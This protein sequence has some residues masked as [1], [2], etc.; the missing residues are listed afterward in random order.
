MI[1]ADKSHVNVP[2]IAQQTHWK[3]GLFDFGKAAVA[4]RYFNP[5]IIN[6][7]GADWLVVRKAA[8]EAGNPFGKNTIWSFKLNDAHKPQYGIKIDFKGYKDQ[9]WEDPRIIRRSDGQ[10]VI[11][12]VTFF[13]ETIDGDRQRWFGAHQQIA[14]LDKDFQPTLVIDPI[15]GNNGGSVM[16]NMVNPDGSPKNEKNWLWFEHGGRLHTVY[17]TDPHRVLTWKKHYNGVEDTYETPA[18]S[19]SWWRFGHARGGTPPVLVGDKYWSFFHSSTPWTEWTSAD[20]RRY[21]MGAYAFEAKPPF[22][23]TRFSKFPLL[24]GSPYD[25]W[26]P[27][28]P[29]VVFPCGALLRNGTWLVTLG[30]NDMASAWIEIPHEELVERT[31]IYGQTQEEEAAAEPTQVPCLAVPESADACGVEAEQGPSDVGVTD[32]RGPELPA[33]AP[34][35]ERREPNPRRPRKRRIRR[36]RMSRLRGADG[37]RNGDVQHAQLSGANA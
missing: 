4:C 19:Q 33:D 6:H 14:D 37:L 13:L 22:R 10:M 2:P 12:Y 36:R 5:S 28:Q 1:H 31:P 29:L 8:D 21:H 26:M 24:T 3:C 34:V 17:L 15:Y 9:H 20:K 16:M 25:P 32:V 7:Q 27:G 30:V 11:S 18:P 23:I 35:P